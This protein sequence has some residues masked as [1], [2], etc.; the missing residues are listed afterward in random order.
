[1]DHQE[2][3]VHAGNFV[4]GG[5]AF[6]IEV[7]QQRRKQ[8]GL[9][10]DVGKA[11]E[12]RLQNQ[13]PIVLPGLQAAGQIHRDTAA[14]GVAVDDPLGGTWLAALQLCPGGI[15]I[16]QQRL[17]RRCDRGTQAPAPVFHRQHG[18]AGLAQRL[19]LGPVLR[20]GAKCAMQIQQRW[21]VFVGMGQPPEFDPLGVVDRA[22][23]GW[24]ADKIMRLTGAQVRQLSRAA[25]CGA[26]D[27]L[28]LAGIEPGATAAGEQ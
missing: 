3:G 17:F 10:R 1:M 9:A 14:H 22:G 12:G 6:V 11:G 13:R 27:E 16:L 4:N 18:K 15:G 19:D 5:K 23:M 7:Q 25:G 28:T 21:R 2:R 24:Q 20:H 26:V 8:S